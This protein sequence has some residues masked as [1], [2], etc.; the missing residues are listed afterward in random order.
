MNLKSNKVIVSF[1]NP[2]KY[3]SDSPFDPPEHYPEY[4]GKSLNPQNKIYAKIRDMFYLLGLDAENFNNKNWNP[5]KDIVKPGMNVFIKPNLVQHYHLK[6]QNIFSVIVHACILR[7][8][9]DYV[10][11][12]L[13]NEGR[14]TIGESQIVFGQFDKAMEISQINALLDWYRNKVS[15]PIDC[16]DLRFN[17]A[18]RTWLYGKWGRTR[19]QKDDHGYRL[20]DLGDLSCFKD[21]DPKKIRI[22]IAS[23]KNMYKHHSNGRHEYAFPNCFLESDVIINI[24]KLKTHRRTGV[25]LALKNSM[26]IPA[27]KDSLPHYMIGSTE[28]GGDHYIH[29]SIRKKICTQ[30]DDHI[31]SVPF[32]IVKFFLT[33]IKKIVWNSH[34]FYP[35]RDNIYEA[36]WPGNDTLWRTLIDLNR[37]IF[38]ADKKGHIQEKPQRNSFCVIDGIIAG[39]K[40]GPLS[41]N[42][43][44]PGALLAGF[45]PV[46]ID[47]VAATLMGFDINKVPIIKKALET[48]N[49]YN[50]LF[51][52]NQDDIMIIDDGDLF[53]LDK[54]HNFRN[55]NF[56]AH[57]NWKDYIELI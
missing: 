27:L 38:Y 17:R 49:K 32:I 14:I 13:K 57:P 50:S 42:P 11:I 53:D 33:A 25:T 10:V 35:F 8:I 44:Y 39:E 28:Q 29:S 37:I 16:I 41:P 6:N 3:P 7:P 9:M 24:A 43:V 15:I 5:L 36:M 40:N 1:L 21:V 54:Y 46:A 20:I 31:Q 26:G 56:E 2:K 23:Y 48:A 19:V 18:V 51:W 30:L 34:M 47:A 52:G 4:S 22:G 12:A 45:N 55:L